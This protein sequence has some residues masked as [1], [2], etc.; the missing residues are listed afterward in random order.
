MKIF[1]HQDTDIV[2]VLE[3][4][5]KGDILSFYVYED[6][7]ITEPYATLTLTVPH[8]RPLNA[9]EFPIKNYSENEGLLEILK[10]NDL[11]YIS[12]SVATGFVVVPIFQF[13]EAKLNGVL[14]HPIEADLDFD[15][16]L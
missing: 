11:G 2:L 3:Q 7:Y 14:Y 1:S 15:L 9:L 12:G 4:G 6:G 16:E 10:Q 13:D 8:C 5:N